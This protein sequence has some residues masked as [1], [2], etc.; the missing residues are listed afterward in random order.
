MTQTCHTWGT[1]GKFDYT[2]PGSLLCP[3]RGS[4]QSEPGGWSDLRPLP[5]NPLPGTEDAT[6][7]LV[8]RSGKFGPP[9]GGVEAPRYHQ[10]TP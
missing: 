9:P 8:K 3:A 7:V 5:G 4:A 10:P 6:G 2:P 1:W